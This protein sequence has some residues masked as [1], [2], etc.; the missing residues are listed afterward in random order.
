MRFE[1]VV[2]K[3]RL[4]VAQFE[5][6]GTDHFLPFFQP[7]FHCNEITSPTGKAYKLLTQY[8][9]GLVTFFFFC[10]SMMNTE[11]LYGA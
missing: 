2:D 10:S 1:T 8:Q 5:Y 4:S 3:D 7:R 9:L 6:T 11:S